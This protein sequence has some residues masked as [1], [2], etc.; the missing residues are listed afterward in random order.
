MPEHLSGAA[1]ALLQISARI[2]REARL[3]L[4][5]RLQAGGRTLPLREAA[6]EL[7]Q[8]AAPLEL[9]GKRDGSTLLIELAPSDMD[10]ERVAKTY[11]SLV[12]GDQETWGIT[13]ELGELVAMYDFEAPPLGESRWLDLVAWKSKYFGDAFGGGL[14]GPREDLVPPVGLGYAAV[15]CI[16]AY[17]GGLVV[18]EGD[19]N[20][21]EHR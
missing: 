20:D 10:A 13:G 4:P 15:I 9:F 3:D 8:R 14:G 7:E 11:W 6:L 1:L 21:R 16:G 5:V 12:A 18:E 17:G 2:M 19:L